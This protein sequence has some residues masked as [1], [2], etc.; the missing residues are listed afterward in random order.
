MELFWVIITIVAA[1]MLY[2]WGANLWKGKVIENP[3]FIAVFLWISAIDFLF[4]ALKALAAFF[5]TTV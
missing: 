1:L 5:G 2:Q 4:D 3:K